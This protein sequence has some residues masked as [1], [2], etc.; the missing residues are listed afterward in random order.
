M[1]KLEQDILLNHNNKEKVKELQNIFEEVHQ[2]EA[3]SSAKHS[4]L[5]K[6]DYV[7]IPRVATTEGNDQPMSPRES[8]AL[9]GSKPPA[10]GQGNPGGTRLLADIPE[11]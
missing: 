6:E 9:Y 5:L 10:F 4:S 2:I 8:I 7:T 1:K 11:E 3:N